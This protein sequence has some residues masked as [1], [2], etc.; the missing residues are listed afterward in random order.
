M[1]ETVE[2]LRPLIQACLKK[3]R[4]SQKELYRLFYA[5][6]IN[7]C[8]HY[9]NNLE[10]AKDIFNDGFFKALT[11]LDQYNQTL[12]FKAWL[13]RILINT[14]IDYHRKYHKNVF[15]MEIVPENEPFTT[16]S[17]F[18][19]L[20]MDDLLAMIQQL[21]PMYRLVF[22]LYILE[23]MKHQEIAEQLKISVGTSKSNLLRAKAKLREMVNQE[24]TEKKSESYFS[25][26]PKTLGTL[27]SLIAIIDN[28]LSPM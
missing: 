4:R 3:D 28:I 18:D 27:L 8:L 26:T 19:N 14:A 11:S 16:E 7:V 23:G 25:K 1:N 10:D 2:K 20:A 24:N 5:Y 22:N 9:S 15:T 17:G 21:T 12:P 13:R 6:G